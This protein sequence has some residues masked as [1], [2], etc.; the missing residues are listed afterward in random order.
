M[1]RGYWRN[2]D[3]IEC[4][5]GARFYRKYALKKGKGILCPNCRTEINDAITLTPSAD[6]PMDDGALGLAG[7]NG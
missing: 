6:T 2:W 7:H 5:C 1:A 3:I 4:K